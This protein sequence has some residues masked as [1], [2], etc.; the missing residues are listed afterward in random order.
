MGRKGITRE[1]TGL[2]LQ[3]L[4]KVLWAF[5]DGVQAEKAVEL[6]ASHLNLT[7]HERGEYE[8]GGRR[9]DKILLFCT[10]D[11]VKAGWM[12]KSDNIWSITPDGKIALE[13]Y[14]QPGQLS[15]EVSRLYRQW[16]REREVDSGVIFKE[17]E[18]QAWK[19]INTFI[20]AM[21]PYTFQDLV[22]TL[23]RALGY[24]VAWVSPAGKDG[25]MA[26]LAWHEPE[27]QCAP[28]IK[29][30]VRRRKDPISGEEMA[31]FLASINGHELGIF[32]STN[33]F[34]AEAA[35]L[36]DAEDNRNIKLFDARALVDL[37]VQHLPKIDPKKR[38]LLP[39]RPIYFLAP[40]EDGEPI[41]SASPPRC[42]PQP[43]A[44]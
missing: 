30:Q 19:E 39:L 25:G 29:V 43:L 6:V 26:F 7:E 9:F 38:C 12:H 44:Q 8:T 20:E 35:D 28:S 15:R 42:D 31:A 2:I 27:G 18:A 34:A 24:F 11:A 13:R 4:L 1:R 33:G 5:A 10:I 21:D 14:P 22:A 16:R 23:L 17:A 40:D 37:W 41:G 3:E 32:L 36:A